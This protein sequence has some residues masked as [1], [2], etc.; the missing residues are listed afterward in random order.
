MR[1]T[2]LALTT[3]QMLALS[4]CG[5][6]VPAQPTGERMDLCV[7]NDS[8]K[9]IYAVVHS[10]SRHEDFGVVGPRTGATIG[11]GFG[12]V[13]QNVKV[14]WTVEDLHGPKQNATLALPAPTNGEVTLTYQV[15][16]TWTTAPPKP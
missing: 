7:R 4:G 8:Q 13:G 9:K 10:G 3:V 1:L 12:A 16:G 5:S 2:L 14:E 11:F 15:D 6:E